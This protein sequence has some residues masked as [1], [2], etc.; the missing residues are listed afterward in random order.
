[1]KTAIYM[2][3]QNEEL[4]DTITS[5]SVISRQTNESRQ[6]FL[7]GNGIPKSMSEK[8]QQ[9]FKDFKNVNLYLSS[10]NLGVAGGRNFL[11]DKINHNFKADFFISLDNDIV[12]PENYFE[13][14]EKKSVELKRQMKEDESLG[15]MSPL[16]AQGPELD[17]PNLETYE[18]PK[19]VDLYERIFH[20]YFENDNAQVIYH[21]GI[22]RWAKHYIVNPGF[23]YLVSFL[24]K[25]IN[26]FFKRIFQ[27]HIKP[28]SITTF[29]AVDSEY[30][31]R[32]LRKKVPEAVDCLPGGLHCYTKELLEAIGPYDNRF[33]PFGYEDA[34]FCIRAKKESFINFLVHDIIII[35]DVGH[36]HINR[37]YKK[38]L[39]TIARCKRLLLIKHVPLLPIRILRYIDYLVFYPLV[40]RRHLKQLNIKGNL[41]YTLIF[42]K[43]F[44]FLK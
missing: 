3:F 36:R 9:C 26:F 13:L 5:I 7:L 31:W 22:R 32:M 28:E 14:I 37:S 4:K 21:I 18:Y 39:Q 17:L 20:I 8:I 35:H 25:F 12:V 29:L 15:I 43:H 16:V 24:L 6:I 40:I 19:D 38:K 1:M 2:L 41:E 11:I 34:D 10:T 27:F 42:W 44:L 33:N 23:Q 30:V